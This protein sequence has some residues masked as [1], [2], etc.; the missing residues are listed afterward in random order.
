MYDIGCWEFVYLDTSIFFRE[1]DLKAKPFYR[2]QYSPPIEEAVEV[3][4][5]QLKSDNQSTLLF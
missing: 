2:K 1:N 3:K 5:I 4:H